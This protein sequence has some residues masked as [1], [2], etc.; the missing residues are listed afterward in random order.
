MRIGRL[1]S[2]LLEPLCR[3]GVIGQNDNKAGVLF[4]DQGDL[5]WVGEELWPGALP[6]MA[7]GGRTGYNKRDLSTG[8][9]VSDPK[10]IQ[11]LSGAHVLEASEE[12][13]DQETTTDSDDEV[14]YD[15]HEDKEAEGWQDTEPR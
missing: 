4:D 15:V 9:E 5:G 13:S 7:I 11:D 2:Q 8:D 12:P 6:I 1:F 10:P 3:G 14:P